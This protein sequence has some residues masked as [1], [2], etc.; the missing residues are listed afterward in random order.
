MSYIREC[1][2]CHKQKNAVYA[3]LDPLRR[4]CA[5][6]YYKYRDQYK[7]NHNTVKETKSEYFARLAAKIESSPP[8]PPVVLP[9]SRDEVGV[10]HIYENVVRKAIHPKAEARRAKTPVELEEI[11]QQQKRNMEYRCKNYT[12]SRSL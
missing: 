5:T 1:A 11:R 6:C 3:K 10:T 4:L 9:P 12:P 8:P 2:C 7:P